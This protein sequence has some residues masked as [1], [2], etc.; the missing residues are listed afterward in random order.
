MSVIFVNS[1]TSRCLVVHPKN[2]R[3]WRARIQFWIGELRIADFQNERWACPIPK[4]QR[5]GALQKLARISSRFGKRLSSWTA[6]ALCRFPQH[7]RRGI[8]VE[9]NP[10]PKQAPLGAAYS[11]DVAPMELGM[12]SSPDATTIPALTGFEIGVHPWLN[13]FTPVVHPKNERTWWA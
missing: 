11:D 12:I 2:E 8:F 4:R 6:A 7:R 3:T 9:S 5:A 1:Q 13:S 10:K